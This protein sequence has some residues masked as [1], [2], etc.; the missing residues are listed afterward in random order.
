VKCP[1]VATT[2]LASNIQHLYTRP[3]SYLDYGNVM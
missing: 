2:A 1:S 3:N